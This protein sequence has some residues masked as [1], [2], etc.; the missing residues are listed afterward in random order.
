MAVEF[1]N[2]KAFWIMLV[3]PCVIAL[4]LWGLHRRKTILG[5]FG[6]ADLLTQFSRLPLNRRIRYRTLVTV[7]CVALL[8]VV[9][10]RPL[11]AGF[12]RNIVKGTLDVVAILDVSKSMAA[13]DCG[14]GVSRIQMAKE[15]LLRC[16]PQL[17]GNRLGMVTFAGKSFPQAELTDDFQA[18]KFVLENWVHTDSA[19]SPG[20]DLGSALSEAAGLFEEDDKEKIILLFSDGGHNRPEKLE[21]ILAD[22]ALKGIRV[23]S[24]GLGSL[25]GSRIPVYENGEFKEWFEIDGKEAVTRLNE[26]I[27]TEIAEATQGRYIQIEF[28]RELDG[29]LKD[30]GLVGKE[31]VSGGREMFQIPLAFSIALLFVGMYFERRSV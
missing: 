31:V 2:V 17:A 24:L 27:L 14:P 18:L 3:L 8:V 22:I 12:S 30:P 10:A 5:E 29:I 11:L 7:F 28:G 1:L 16:L 19:P 4:V 15:M 25:K 13:E 23:V 21:G 20:S 6:E 26:S 9:I